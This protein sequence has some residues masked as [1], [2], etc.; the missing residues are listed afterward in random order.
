MPVPIYLLPLSG[1]CSL[2]AALLYTAFLARK[3][4]TLDGPAKTAADCAPIV[5]VA[6]ASMLLYY[7]FLFY[8]SA[9][10]FIE[11]SKAQRNYRDKKSERQEKPNLGKIKYGAD[12]YK[13]HIANRTVVNYS[14]QIVPFLVSLFLCA[15]FASVGKASTYGWMWLFFRSY[16]PLAFRRPFPSLFL[17]TL[18]AYVCVW[19]MLGEAVV[20]VAGM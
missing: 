7:I 5:Y 8:Q 20:A 19:K 1:A 9:T 18:P 10:A 17:S 11:F 13:I 3:T 2:A 14:E 6:V 16:Y 15:T 4:S 12:N